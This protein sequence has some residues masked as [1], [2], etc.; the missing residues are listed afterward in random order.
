[1]TA[2]FIGERSKKLLNC[3]TEATAAIKQYFYD[4]KAAKAAGEPLVWTSTWEPQEIFRAMDINVYF[5][6]HY[7]VV[8]AAKGMSARY[9]DNLQEAGWSK[10][11]CR[12]CGQRLGF[13]LDK[14]HEDAPWGG[15]PLPDLELVSC[16]DDLQA[17]IFQYKADL[18]GFPVYFTE[19][20]WPKRVSKGTWHEWDAEEYALE[21][22]IKQYRQLISYLEHFFH[23]ELNMER[24]KEVVRYTVEMF[25]LWWEADELRKAVPA[26]ITAADFYSNIIPVQFFRGTKQGVEMLT[27][28]RDEIKERVDKG[29][30]AV[31]NERLRL[32]WPE[33]IPYFTPGIVNAFEEKYGA[34]IVCETAYHLPEWCHKVDPEKP[35]EALAKLYD[36]PYIEDFFNAPGKLETTVEL[37]RDFSIDGVI[38]MWAESCKA[39]CNTL[40]LTQRALSKC[41]IPSIIIKGDFVD[42]RDWDDQKIK[43]EI[44]AFIETLDP[45]KRPEHKRRAT[46]FLERMGSTLR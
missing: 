27:K 14:N 32:Y 40:L 31:P 16:V 9:L 3:S 25:R 28:Y 12:Y 10:D 37:A 46:E 19:R 18:A 13:F 35:I 1:M 42:I 43:S 45:T 34:A 24:L 2:Q 4:I 44:G 23:R 26:P 11:V 5:M 41:G 33:L 20:A 8:C 39:F 7:T 22:S 29:L 36:S 6:V 17:K 15:A 21:Y 30:A 38:I